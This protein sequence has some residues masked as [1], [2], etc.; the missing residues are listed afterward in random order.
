[1][2]ALKAA[3]IFMGVLIVAGVALIIV[4]LA[5]RFSE[6]KATGFGERSLAAPEGCSIASAEAADDRLIV[7]LDGLADRGC[8]QVLVLDLETGETLG[9]LSLTA[10][11]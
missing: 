7:R 2:Q 10:T 6:D 3:V 11:Q 8:Q 9:R 4:T 1:M 5:S